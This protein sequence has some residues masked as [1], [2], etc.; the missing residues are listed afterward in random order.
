MWD[1]TVP[2]N[3]DHDFYVL[4]AATAVL[5]HNC[6]GP[7]S[8]LASSMRSMLAQRAGFSGSGTRLIVDENLP[9]AWASGLRAAGYDAQS[10]A[11]MGL[12]GASDQELNQLA[13]QVGAKVLT[14]DVGHQIEGGFGANAIQ[15][16]SRIR[17]LST[18]FQ[19][20]GG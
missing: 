6:G 12:N 17:S 18:I 14:R 1:L 11:E 20:L 15:V 10:V 9:S 7:A 4:A 19:L 3:N 16:D 8:E 2:G 5:V 13:E